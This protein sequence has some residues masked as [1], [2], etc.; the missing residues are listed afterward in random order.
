MDV[1]ATNTSRRIGR[2]LELLVASLSETL[3]GESSAPVDKTTWQYLSILLR[4]EGVH[5]DP[6]DG[7][8]RHSIG[9]QESSPTKCSNQLYA[10]N[11]GRT[12]TVR[13]LAERYKDP[14]KG[15][16]SP[17]G[18]PLSSTSIFLQTKKDLSTH[19]HASRSPHC[20]RRLRL[21]WRRCSFHPRHR[22]RSQAVS[23]A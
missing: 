5:V 16:T 9:I 11:Q 19:N 14:S 23:P 7:V 22:L 2:K 10:S 8:K 17:S 4:P 15:R 6:T 1:A 12:S 18:L 21:L 3:S 13:S 20:H